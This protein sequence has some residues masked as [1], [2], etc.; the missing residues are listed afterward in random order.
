MWN[1]HTH[2]R[3]HTS[4]YYKAESIFNHHQTVGACELNMDLDSLRVQLRV[5]EL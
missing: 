3:R 2:A 1:K 5:E 4:T